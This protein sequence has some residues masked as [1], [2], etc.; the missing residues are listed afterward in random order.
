[1][2]RRQLLQ[3]AGL[4]ALMPAGACAQPAKLD[5]GGKATV[6]TS[7]QVAYSLASALAAGT[8]IAVRNTPANGSPM[9]GLNRALA[10]Q[11]PEA[12]ADATAV[13]DIAKLW[14]DDPL[15]PAARAHSLTA[16]QIDASFPWEHDETG[17]GVQV[18]ATPTDDASWLKKEAAVTQPASPY[19]WLS[20]PNGIRMAELIAADFERIVPGDAAR[21]RANLA[22]ISQVLSSMK[23]EYEATFAASSNA[24]VFALANEFVYLFAD[25]GLF[26]DAWFTRQDV[27]WT[28][29]DYAGLTKHLK[30]R[31]LKV[32]VH[33]W[34]PDAKVKAAVTAAGAKLVILNAGDSENPGPLAADG[35]QSLLKSNLDT[36]AKALAA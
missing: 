35:Y 7:L 15:Y 21:V 1:M 16:I 8:G 18:I 28:A 10:R 19:V 25:M 33:K 9:D 24:R 13:V 27:D 32:V 12:F 17:K 3:L 26:V 5:G 11:K 30:A 31:G 2:R 20:L 34:E 22:A 29:A 23:A 36:L 14:A 4:A 6:L